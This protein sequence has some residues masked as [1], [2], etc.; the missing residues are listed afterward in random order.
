MA[1]QIPAPPSGTT[2]QAQPQAQPSGGQIPPPPSGDIVMA[3]D[4]TPD[5][6]GNAE[7]KTGAAGLAQYAENVGVGAAKGLESTTEG[8]GSLIQKIPGIGDKLIPQE[9]LTAE[10]KQA[11]PQGSDQFV[12]YAGENLAE[13]MLGDEALK[14]LSMADKFKQISGAMGILEKSPRLM[15]AIQMGADIG[16]AQTELGPEEQAALKKSPMLARLVGAGM[17]ALRQGAVAGVQQTAKT[18]SPEKGLEAGAEQ[19]AASGVLGT[20]FSTLGRVAEKAGEA[21]KAVQ[22]AS[23]AGKNA[24][25]SLDIGQK[26]ADQINDAETKMHGDFESGIQKLRGDL[27]DQKVPYQ[28]SPLQKAATE[29]MEGRADVPSQ[30]TTTLGSAFKGIAGGSDKTLN[31]LTDLTQ[32]NKTGDLTIDELVQ[33]RQQ[34]SAKIGQILKGS[35]SSEDRADVAVYQKLRD[36]IDDTIQGLAKQSGKP[37]ASQDYDALRSAY[38]DKV[39]LFQTPAIQRLSDPGIDSATKLDNAAKYL[40]QG[41]DKLN[42]INTL[43]ETIG[44]PAVKDLGKGILQ[45]KL[46]EASSGGQIN[47]A[48]FVKNFKQIDQ[49]PPEVK[50]K[51]FDSGGAQKGLDKLSGDLKT[52]AN[53]QKLIRAGIVLNPVSGMGLL[54]GSL[55]SGDADGARELLD[56]IANRPGMWSAFRT[57]GKIGATL[58]QSPAA[59]RVGTAA[60]G[61]LGNVLQGATEPLSQPEDQDQ[62]VYT[63]Q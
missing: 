57:A 31:M 5:D 41:G 15:R 1:D 10:N 42:K 60:K 7:D 35:T 34:L 56:K 3:Q 25:S 63:N 12:G 39:K 22:E 44:E 23:E 27:G 61:A 32:P 45:S 19:T 48:K 40:L 9:G 28:G 4:Q 29:A 47:P 43:S 50:E 58:E 2:V 21:G 8:I 6:T 59:R 38:K 49:L 11:T 24:P 13:F 62:V 17:D 52:A 51:L 37:E 54:L 30:K 33:R 26:V 53:Y 55:A 46:A 14:G 16:K 20:A 36:G 18:G